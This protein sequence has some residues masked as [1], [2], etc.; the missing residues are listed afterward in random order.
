MI[1]KSCNSS[2]TKIYLKVLPSSVHKRYRIPF[3]L[4]KIFCSSAF[5]CNFLAMSLQYASFFCNSCNCPGFNGK[6]ISLTSSCSVTLTQKSFCELYECS[7]DSLTS[8]RLGFFNGCSLYLSS[9]MPTSF[10][11]HE[12]CE[13][14]LNS[15]PSACVFVFSLQL[16]IT[17]SLPSFLLDNFRNFCEQSIVSPASMCGSITSVATASNVFVGSNSSKQ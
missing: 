12:F 4:I 15:L 1:M 6:L 9:N 17:S 11:I 16:F 8:R 14:L 10:T 2:G 3:S 13:Y 5:L 7:L